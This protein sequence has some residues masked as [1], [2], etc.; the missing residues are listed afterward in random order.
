M[1]RAVCVRIE[2][3]GLLEGYVHD[4]RRLLAQLAAK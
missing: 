4:A 2:R 3:D 1:S